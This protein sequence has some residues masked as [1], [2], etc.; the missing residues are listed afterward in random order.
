MN[1]NHKQMILFGLKFE[2][3]YFENILTNEKHTKETS[4][5]I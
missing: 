2:V 4:L 5:K 1:I 3:F